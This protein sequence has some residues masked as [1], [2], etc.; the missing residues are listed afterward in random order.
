M[1]RIIRDVLDEMYEEYGM[2]E[3]GFID[4]RKSPVDELKEGDYNMMSGWTYTVDHHAPS[5]NIDK[6]ELE[7]GQ[8]VRVRYTICW[9]ADVGNAEMDEMMESSGIGY[10]Y[11]EADKLNLLRQM[12]KINDE[13]ALKTDSALSSRNS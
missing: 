13:S 12:A 1:P 11:T 8:V 5:V 10:V 4:T 6:Q 9:G 2:D 7:A 3:F